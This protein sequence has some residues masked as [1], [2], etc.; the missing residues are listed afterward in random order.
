MLFHLRPQLR[1][2]RASLPAETLSTKRA[3]DWSR[4]R[5]ALREA[6]RAQNRVRVYAAAGFVPNSYRYTC[7]IQYIEAKVCDGRIAS[8]GAGWCGAQRSGGRGALVVVQ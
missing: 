4:V 5:I 8:I 7:K 2:L 1:A 6:A 3:C